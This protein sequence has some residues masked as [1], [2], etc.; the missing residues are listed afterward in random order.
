MC[1]EAGNRR[2]PSDASTICQHGLQESF[3][4]DPRCGESDPRD[5]SKLREVRLRV[6]GLAQTLGA[7]GDEALEDGAGRRGSTQAGSYIPRSV[8]KGWAKGQGIE[9]ARL[10]TPVPRDVGQVQP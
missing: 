5:H 1:A 8:R 10:T 7:V 2:V 6:G 4:K 3:S 9:H